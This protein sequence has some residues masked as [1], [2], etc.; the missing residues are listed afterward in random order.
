[1]R[2]NMKKVSKLMS[3]WPRN[4]RQRKEKRILGKEVSN[5]RITMSQSQT[6]S[7]PVG[8]MPTDGNSGFWKDLRPSI[9][10]T[11]PPSSD[12]NRVGLVPMS[13]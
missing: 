2:G 6:A 12:Y 8:H 9:D 5:I 10:I 3:S 13:K 4:I 7:G 1:M 11:M